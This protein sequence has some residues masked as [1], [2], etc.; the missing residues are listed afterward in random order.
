MKGFY[1]D[2]DDVALSLDLVELQVLQSLLTDLQ[3][4]IEPA[5]M[6]DA[7]PLA[8]IVGID[9]TV[10][11]PTDEAMVRLFPDAYVDDD[12]ASMEFRRFTERG[13]RER[14]REQSKTV[15]LL[16][17]RANQGPTTLAEPEARA[18]LGVLNDMRIVLGVRLGIEQDEDSWEDLFEPDDPRR[19][20]HVAYQWLTWL[21]QELIVSM[22][23][24]G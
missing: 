12:E 13:L 7:D 15:E 22:T 9:E 11:H 24:G 19:H 20:L 6:Q 8:E 21:Q 14:R 2:G 5:P 18:A 3:E 16:L 17:E 1:R 4:M 10:A 23:S